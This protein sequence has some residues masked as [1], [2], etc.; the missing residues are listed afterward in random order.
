MILSN[1][2]LLSV[3]GTRAAGFLPGGRATG[4]EEDHDGCYGVDGV[5]ADDGPRWVEVL[6]EKNC[7]NRRAKSDAVIKS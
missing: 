3:S 1:L 4:A 2:V 5:R 7:F 6:K